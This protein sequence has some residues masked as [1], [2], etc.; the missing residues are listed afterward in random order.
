MKKILLFAAVVLSLSVQGYAK[1]SAT[2]NRAVGAA[3][4]K[5][6]ANDTTAHQLEQSNDKAGEKNAIG[7]ARIYKNEKSVVKEVGDVITNM[8]LVSDAIVGII[9]ILGIF[10]SPFA[11]IVLVMFFILRARRNKQKLQAELQ[12]KALEQGKELPADLFA[13]PAKKSNPLNRGVMYA[14][15]GVGV[16]VFFTAAAGVAQGVMFG[17]IPLCVGLGYLLIY[18][19]NKKRNDSGQC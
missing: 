10:V 7:S 9:A 18:Y 8:A 2:E 11:A 14:A 4:N 6:A 15:V 13:Q 17:A 5:V 3:T 19:L 1:N 12:L 16:G